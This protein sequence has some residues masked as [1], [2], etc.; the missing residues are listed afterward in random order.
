MYLISNRLV[1]VQ[2]KEWLMTKFFE[3]NY[4]E[5][6][7]L[8][9][10]DAMRSLLNLTKKP[11]EMLRFVDPTATYQESSIHIAWK[12]TMILIKIFRKEMQPLMSPSPTQRLVL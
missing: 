7:L 9:R 6:K 11:A 5:A 12:S 4:S 2:A 3:D 8:G 1:N 10:A